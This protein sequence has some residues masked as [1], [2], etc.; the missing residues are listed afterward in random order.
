MYTGLVG[1]TQ[2]RVRLDAVKNILPGAQTQQRITQTDHV[3]RGVSAP[4]LDMAELL[5]RARGIT[6]HQVQIT[7][8]RARFK[9]A[10]IGLQRI[11]EL[12]H[13]LL[14]LP[15]LPVGGRV[16]Q[17]LAETFHILGLAG[18]ADQ[19]GDQHQDQQSDV[20]LCRYRHIDDRGW[21]YTGSNKISDATDQIYTRSMIYF[22]PPG[23][24][25]AIG[26]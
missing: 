21:L 7:Q 8:C 25:R 6:Q 22:D 1:H 15:L 3:Q 5:I 2:A 24:S 23:A 9:A 26:C 4:T 16:F 14:D 10:R 19:E 20:A 11:L 12:D 17:V 13:G 18:A